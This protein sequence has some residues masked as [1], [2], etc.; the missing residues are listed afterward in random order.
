[1]KETF[2]KD[3]GPI[4]H[5]HAP[6][7]YPKFC[8]VPVPGISTTPPTRGLPRR[9]TKRSLRLANQ[10][11]VKL[12]TEIS[13]YPKVREPRS[14]SRRGVLLSPLP[15]FFD[16]HTLAPGTTMHPSFCLF[17]HPS[18][19]ASVHDR[20]FAEQPPGGHVIGPLWEKVRNTSDCLSPVSF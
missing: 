10:S 13:G 7:V 1:M 17:L 6:T 15:I 20:R 18:P 16:P 14:G 19:C 3:C 11:G 2:A 12:N 4:Q 9:N 5:T 8:V